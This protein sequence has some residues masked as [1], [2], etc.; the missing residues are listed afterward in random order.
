[1][2]V[3]DADKLLELDAY[4]SYDMPQVQLTSR[5]FAVDSLLRIVVLVDNLLDRSIIDSKLMYFG[6]Y[7][8]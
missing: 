4:A 1:M 5:V 7:C 8:V 2:D 6:T 3:D